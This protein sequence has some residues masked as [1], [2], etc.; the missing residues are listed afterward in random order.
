MNYYLHYADGTTEIRH[1]CDKCDEKEATF[2]QYDK[3]LCWDCKEGTGLFS[4]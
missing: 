1:Y 2:F 4:P 3:Q